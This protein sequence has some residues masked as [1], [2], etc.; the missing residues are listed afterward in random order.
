MFDDVKLQSMFKRRKQMYDIMVDLE[1][2]GIK[3]N[4]IVLSIG[5]VA[6]DLKTGAID[7]QFYCV[8]DPVSCEKAGMTMNAS[9]AIWW[10]QQSEEARMAVAGRQD[11]WT[12]GRACLEF[13]NFW[14]EYKSPKFWSHATF[15]EGI[16]RNMYEAADVICP[17][18]YRDTRDLR[19]LVGLCPD[20]KT[21]EIFEANKR[22]GV[23]H[24][25]LDDAM[26]QAHYA[27]A[28]YKEI[29]GDKYA[30]V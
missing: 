20:D 9:T 1:T 22:G 21:K 28:I 3:K 6:F 17:W 29:I 8:V 25:A 13:Q 26:F 5:A 18:H 15:D 4:A 11:T 10:M 12:I 14:V 16:L 30:Q 23:H 24:N 2:L 27:H 7:N 19:T